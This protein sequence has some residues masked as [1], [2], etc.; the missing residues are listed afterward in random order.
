MDGIELLAEGNQA[1]ASLDLST[2]T[3]VELGEVLVALQREQAKLIANKIRVMGAFEAR[4]GHTA[5][6]SRTAAAWLARATHCAPSEARALVRHG[7]RLPHMPATREA[8]ETGEITERHAGV[9]GSLYASARKPVADAFAE[10]EDELVG[11]ARELPFDDFLAAV[12]YWESLVDADGTEDQAADDH[13]ARY[14]HLSEIWR[15]N[16]ALDGQLDPLG[17]EEVHAELSRLEQELFRHDWDQAKTTHGDDTCLEHL[18]RTPA[19]RRADALV[20]MA[21]GRPR[22]RL[23]RWSLGRCLWSTLV[24]NP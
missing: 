15:S 24:T 8:L 22:S 21:A 11:Y 7:R 9:L 5:D 1:L 14:L 2:V 10:A 12:R 16:W 18:A 17:G 23:M 3:A 6:G 4:R 20:E 19:Q 13:A